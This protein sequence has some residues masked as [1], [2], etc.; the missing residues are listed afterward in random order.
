MPICDRLED[1]ITI[2]QNEVSE[3]GI[4]RKVDQLNEVHI[5]K[6]PCVGLITFWKVVNTNLF[7]WIIY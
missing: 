6:H 7:I 4:L 5:G 3:E 1:R 2:Q